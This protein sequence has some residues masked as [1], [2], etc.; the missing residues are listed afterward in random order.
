VT[1]QV[2]R[3]ARFDPEIVLD[4]IS[5]NRPTSL[6]LNHVDY[7]DIA[8]HRTGSATAKVSRAVRDI[9]VKL[10]HI[11]D[12]VGLGQKILV[13]RGTLTNDITP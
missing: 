5:T 12:L 3:V 4:A 2:R 9:E 1:D 8:S 7:F 6:V 13:P 11:V 10:G